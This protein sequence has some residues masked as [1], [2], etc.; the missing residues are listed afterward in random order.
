M[1]G[2]FE[3][4][5]THFHRPAGAGVALGGGDDAAL[6]EPTLGRQLAVT[7]DTLVAGTHFLADADAA[8]IGFKA[9][10][11]N[12]S[13]LAAMGAQPRWAQL[14]LTLPDADDAWCAGFASGLFAALDMAGASLTGGDLTRGPLTVTLTLIGEVQPPALTRAG[15]RPDDV[16]MLTGPVGEAAAGLAVARGD[17]APEP[18]HAAHL[19]SRL[20]RP[21]A[22]IAAGQCA[23]GRASACIDVSDGVLADLGHV[24]TASGVGAELDADALPVS[25]ALLATGVEPARLAAWQWTG[26]DDYELLMAVPAEHRDGVLAD[27]RGL[28]LQPVVI[29]RVTAANGIVWAGGVAPVDPVSSGFRH[30]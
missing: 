23:R 30:F 11:V 28:G 29:G 12:L 10:M 16:L 9:A 26:G 27:L 3:L 7:T 20:H 8:D 4:I 6:L 5:R 21:S 13:D 19:L 2:E 25:E 24:L 22:R 17:I 18:V 1:S 15:A 14:A